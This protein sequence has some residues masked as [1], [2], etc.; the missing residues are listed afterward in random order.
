L[1]HFGRAARGTA[2]QAEGNHWPPTRQ[3]P[4]VTPGLHAFMITGNL[5]HPDA[6]TRYNLPSAEIER[7]IAGLSPRSR[8]LS[9]I[10][11]SVGRQQLRADWQEFLLSP[12]FAHRREHA[13]RTQNVG[14][15]RTCR[16]RSRLD[17][18][19]ATAPSTNSNWVEAGSSQ[20]LSLLQSHSNQAVCCRER[21]IAC[22]LR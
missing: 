2:P 15:W 10:A 18:Q 20:P 12:A 19:T 16:V 9:S 8:V 6:I 17:C 3:C 14:N 21:L 7:V 5:G 22:L 13:E 11:L 4:L 1:G